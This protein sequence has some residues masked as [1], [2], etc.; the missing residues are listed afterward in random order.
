MARS[1]D[2]GLTFSS[3]VTVA[4]IF[5]MRNDPAVGYNRNRTNDHPRIAV[6]TSGP[7]KGRV[8]VTY[9]SAVDPVSP[10]PIVTCPSGL[11]AGSICIGQNLISTQVY[12]KFSDDNGLTW[13]TPVALSTPLLSG[14]TDT[15]RFWPVVSIEPSGAVDVVYYE[16]AEIPTSSNPECIKRVAVLANGTFVFRVGT[17]NSLVDTFWTESTD[18]GSTYPTLLKMTTTTSNWCTAVSNVTP[19]FGDYI[20]ASP[21]GNRVF[22]VWGDGRNGIPDTFFATGLGV[23]KTK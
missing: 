17:A 20:G 10:V 22:G 11:P 1:L 21:G 4:N 16:S 14:S 5:S 8:Y 9:Y 23:S 15:K 12:V 6:A 18:G 13:S 7:H 2:G 3:P 19:N